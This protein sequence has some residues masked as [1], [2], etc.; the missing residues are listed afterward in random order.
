MSYYTQ[1]NEEGIIVY[2]SFTTDKD[3]VVPEGHRLLLDSPPNPP[4]YTPGETYPV[5]VEPVASDATEISY[6]IE[7]VLK[8]VIVNPNEVLL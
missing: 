3:Y 8:N 7:T 4:D 6:R 2:S 1:V 5:R